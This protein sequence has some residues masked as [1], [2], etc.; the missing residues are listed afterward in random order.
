[1][2]NIIVFTFLLMFSTTVYASPTPTFWSDS[3]DAGDGI[4]RCDSSFDHGL[5][6][7]VVQTPCGEMTVPQVC[8]AIEEKFGAGPLGNRTYYNSVQCGHGPPNTAN[9]ELI[10][11]GI[12]ADPPPWTGPRCNETA[13]QWPLEGICE[14]EPAPDLS[15]TNSVWSQTLNLQAR[16]ITD[17][18]I[19]KRDDVKPTM[20]N[21][22]GAVM[23]TFL[24]VVMV[25]VM[26]Y[27]ND[28]R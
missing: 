4:C 5:A 10:C 27:K 1:M 24:F 20:V 14:T 8:A 13:S 2:K 12:P 26:G 28:Q 18:E 15:C 7:M 19:Q 22:L 3:Y 11:P 6:A 17:G 21:I 23:M 16:C 25:T 9:D